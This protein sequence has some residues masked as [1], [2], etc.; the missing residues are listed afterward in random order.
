MVFLTTRP[1][2]SVQE[3]DDDDKVCPICFDK[4]EED[5]IEE[6][7]IRLP[8]GHLC[9]SGCLSR[10]FDNDSRCPLC[11]AALSD[12]VLR[13]VAI[14]MLRRNYE[15]PA[16]TDNDDGYEHEHEQE[17]AEATANEARDWFIHGQY[18]TLDTREAEIAA[19]RS[20]MYRLLTD[21]MLLNPLRVRPRIIERGLQEIS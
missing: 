15:K 20:A 8:C 18:S 3:L 9:G 6:P 5:G 11:R 2:P 10:H 21:G 14:E 7:A 19:S 17:N 4:Y 16:I 1:R 13:E 12:E